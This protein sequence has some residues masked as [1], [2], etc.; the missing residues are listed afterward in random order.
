MAL[1]QQPNDLAL[2]DRDADSPEQGYQTRH[3][4]LALV[5]LEQHE[6][7]QLRPEMAGDAGRHRGDYRPPVRSQPAL[8]AEADHVRPQ[9]EVLDQ[10]VLVAL[11]ARAGRDIRPDDPVLVDDEPPDLASL[12]AAA[13]LR[14]LRPGGLVHATGL[15]LGPALDAFERRDLRPQLGDRLS[16]RGVLGQRPLGKGL[17]LA[18]RQA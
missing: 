2:G 10:E 11:E 4:H 3:G 14:R 5:V 17:K 13:L 18:A 15:E 16:Q 6:P 8:A 1:V 7:T 12:G 9:H